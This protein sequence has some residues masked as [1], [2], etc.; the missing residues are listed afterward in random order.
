MTY[1]FSAQFEA[2][3]YL[4]IWALLQLE[5]IWS[6]LHWPFKNA[7][8]SPREHVLSV[9][10]AASHIWSSFLA[11]LQ[12]TEWIDLFKMEFRFY[13]YTECFWIK[14]T[15]KLCMILFLG[16]I[17]HESLEE[18]KRQGKQEHQPVY[19]LNWS[20]VTWFTFWVQPGVP[21]SRRFDSGPSLPPR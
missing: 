14:H 19:W 13:L 6:L 9:A 20:R 5:S 3:V 4:C 11:G 1:I 18:D 21:Y 10:V 8:F 15:H 16:S 7:G 2:S 12:G 17:A